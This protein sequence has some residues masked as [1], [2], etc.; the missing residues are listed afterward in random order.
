MWR[1]FICSERTP[2]L[3]TGCKCILHGLFK[4]ILHIVQDTYI[5]S[6]LKVCKSRGLLCMWRFIVCSERTPVLCTGCKCILHGLFKCI[7]H[8]VQDTHICSLVKV[9]KRRGLLCMWRFIVCSERTPLH[10]E[11]YCLQR[12]DSCPVGMST[13][14]RDPASLCLP[15]SLFTRPCNMN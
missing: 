14:A 4:Y 6:L 9:C 7:L 13:I 1:F 5:C 2:V 8:F 3:F 11:V 10:V 12:K 15:Y